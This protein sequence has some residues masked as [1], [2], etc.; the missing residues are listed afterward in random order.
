MAQIGF[1]D[2]VAGPVYTLLGQHFP[3]F[4]VLDEE[5]K[6]NKHDWEQLQK[7]GPYEFVTPLSILTAKTKAD[8]VC[9]T[10][11]TIAIDMV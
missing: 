2:F 8:T 11:R 7:Q 10:E 4:K 5:T 9:G 3:E 1:I 6:R